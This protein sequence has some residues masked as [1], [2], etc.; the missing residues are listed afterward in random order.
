MVLDCLRGSWHY[1][2]AALVLDGHG[3]LSVGW[4]SI[5]KGELGVWCDDGEVA[6]V[7]KDLPLVALPASLRPVSFNHDADFSASPIGWKASVLPV[8]GNL[9]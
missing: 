5:S 4:I 6:H 9:K 3:I 7:S 8:I 2:C 1:K